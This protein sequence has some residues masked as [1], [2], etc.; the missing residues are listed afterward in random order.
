MENA[1]ALGDVGNQRE[2][3]TGERSLHSPF[4][5]PFVSSKFNIYSRAFFLLLLQKKVF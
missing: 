3:G 5:S 1:A 4:S 2:T